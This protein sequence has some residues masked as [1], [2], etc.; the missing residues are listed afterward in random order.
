ML[1]ARE[2]I[3]KLLDKDTF[4]EVNMLGRHNVTILEWKKRRFLA[5][6]L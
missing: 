2:R 1:T 3:E 4:V 6:G 5:M